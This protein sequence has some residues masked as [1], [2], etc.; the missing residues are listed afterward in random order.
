MSSLFKGF[1]DLKVLV[2]GDVMLDAY[3]YGEVKRISPEAPI[4]VVNVTEK[5]NC[6]GGAANVALNGGQG[7]SNAADIALENSINIQPTIH[8]DQGS[9][10]KVFVGQDLDFKLAASGR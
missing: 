5:S 8:I 2:V 9:R 7:F 4:P 1:D 3:I 10:I 6:L